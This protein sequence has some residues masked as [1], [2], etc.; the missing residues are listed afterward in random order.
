M[1]EHLAF[2]ESKIYIVDFL[3][4]FSDFREIKYKK[5]NVDFH[6]V[7]HENKI[8]DTLDFFELFFTKYLAYTK[9]NPK[10][11]FLFVMKKLHSYN[12]LLQNILLK[13][14]HLDITFII[15]EDRFKDIILEKNKDD[16]MCQYIFHVLQKKYDCHLISN[17]KYRDRISYVSL[18]DFDINLTIFQLENPNLVFQENLKLNLKNRLVDEMLHKKYCRCS[19]PKKKLINIL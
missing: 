7:K 4:I 16:F 5:E 12:D 2:K 10:S 15:I 19:I 14:K 6:K 17:D 3:N 11:S 1:F 13:Y 8:S 18:F 9:I